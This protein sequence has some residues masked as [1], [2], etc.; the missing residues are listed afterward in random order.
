M[1]PDVRSDDAAPLLRAIL[2]LSKYHREH[3]KFYA[4]SPREAAVALQT[5]ART[6]QA[7]ADRWSTSDPVTPT[8]FSP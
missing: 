2:N 5:H 1:A 8:P 3:E 6:L 4:S 7:L